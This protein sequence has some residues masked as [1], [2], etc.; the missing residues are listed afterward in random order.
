MSR[1]R[2]ADTAEYQ[3]EQRIKK[4]ENELQEAHELQS[5]LLHDHTAKK[6]LLETYESI[7][8]PL[9]WISGFLALVS[10]GF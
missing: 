8:V 10:L 7:L 3:H 1:W 4:L 2:Q 9:V 6:K 5:M